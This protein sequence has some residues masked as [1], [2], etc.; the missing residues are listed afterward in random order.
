MVLQPRRPAERPGR[1]RRGAA[2]GAD[3]RH[4][5]PAQPDLLDALQCGARRAGRDLPRERSSPVLGRD[6]LGHGARVRRTPCLVLRAVRAGGDPERALQ[7]ARPSRAAGRLAGHAGRAGHVE[8]AAVQGLRHHLRQRPQR[9]ARDHRAEARRGPPGARLGDH[10]GEPAAP[11]GLLRGVLG[12]LR[13]D[14]GAIPR[15]RGPRGA[16]RLGGQHG[17]PELRRLECHHGELR[18]G[19]VRLLRGPK[20]ARRA[21]RPGAP[22]LSRGPGAP[23]AAPPGQVQEIRADLRKS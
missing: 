9:G 18:A 13:V 21:L 20:P 2:R 5:F 22:Q 3:G 14:P 7:A 19:A 1:R 11:Q 17:R 6:V 10:A 23:G 12:P 4:E 8:A 15:A 16:A